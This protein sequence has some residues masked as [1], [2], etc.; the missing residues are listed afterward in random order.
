MVAGSFNI[1]CSKNALV[2]NLKEQIN[3]QIKKD[4]PK[5]AA[6]FELEELRVGER[7]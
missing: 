5:L 2:G 1:K 3:N 4:Y 7:L 6:K